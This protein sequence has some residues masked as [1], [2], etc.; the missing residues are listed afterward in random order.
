MAICTFCPDLHY[1]QP[2]P[3]PQWDTYRYSIPPQ[4]GVAKARGVPIRQT[5]ASQTAA[6]FQPGTP[7]SPIQCIFFSSSSDLGG[8]FGGSLDT[9]PPWGHVND[10][11]GPP[12]EAEFSLFGL[13]VSAKCRFFPFV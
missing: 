5:R 8:G 3:L 10:L 1:L 12:P 4:Y 6:F 9:V 7:P 2:N 11:V 13:F